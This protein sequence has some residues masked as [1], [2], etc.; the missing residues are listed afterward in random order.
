M[1]HR[2]P[3]NSS[4]TL[5]QNRFLCVLIAAALALCPIIATPRSVGAGQSTGDLRLE[6]PAN[7]NIER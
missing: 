5:S 4:P 3:G 2:A 6:L 7:G 1:H